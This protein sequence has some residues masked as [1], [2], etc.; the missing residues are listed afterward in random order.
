MT[1][2]VESTDGHARNAEIVRLFCRLPISLLQTLI[3]S[4]FCRLQH[5]SSRFMFVLAFGNWSE[6]SILP[7]EAADGVHSKVICH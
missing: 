3:L 5:L 2:A 6:S 7:H 1:I 4:K